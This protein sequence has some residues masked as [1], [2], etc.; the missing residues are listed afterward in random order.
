MRKKTVSTP[1][2]TA[3][4]VLQNLDSMPEHFFVLNGDVMV[5]VDMPRMARQHL[6]R[7]SDFTALVHPN[8]HPLDSDLGVSREPTGAGLPG[9]LEAGFK[10]DI[11]R[12][13]ESLGF[14]PV[15]GF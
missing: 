9:F 13:F 14:K 15:G 7:R 3:G 2:G 4:A 5:A 10:L 6:E 8:D 11:V 12:L 1:L